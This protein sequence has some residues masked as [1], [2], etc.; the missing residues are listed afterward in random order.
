MQVSVRD[1][2]FFVFVFVFVFAF[3]QR[4]RRPWKH[5]P[6]HKTKRRFWV[7]GKTALHSYKCWFVS[8]QNFGAGATHTSSP[9]HEIATCILWIVRS[10]ELHP[11]K[12]R[13]TWLYSLF[14]KISPGW[15]A[16]IC[17]TV[18]WQT[19]VAENALPSKLPTIMFEHFIKTYCQN[20][21]SKKLRKQVIEQ[22][23]L[24]SQPIHAKQSS[25][26]L[27]RRRNAK[28]MSKPRSSRVF[29]KIVYEGIFQNPFSI[30]IDILIKH[31]PWNN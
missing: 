7:A 2:C 17:K 11:N 28:S 20:A 31:Q 23:G 15:F 19:D 24:S 6:K 9:I 8:H 16:Q 18:C 29:S 25:P 27:R 12:L 10:S 22:R 5:I 3:V 30:L 14:G 13:W 21:V 1:M 26:K 4:A